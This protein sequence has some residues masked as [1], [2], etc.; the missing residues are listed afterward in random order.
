M[1][2]IFKTMKLMSCHIKYINFSLN[3]LTLLKQAG[4]GGRID[5]ESH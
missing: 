1:T 5:W 2:Y 3:L 4:T